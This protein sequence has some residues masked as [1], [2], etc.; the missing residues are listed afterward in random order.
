MTIIYTGPSLLDGAPIVVITISNSK[1]AKTGG[2]IQTYILRKD[3]DPRD[4]SKSGADYSI[5]GSC[6]ARGV[7]T[8]DPKVKL[9]VRRKCY[10]TIGQGPLIVWRKYCRGGY[11]AAPDAAAIAAIGADRMVRLGTYGDPAVV[12]AY[13]WSALLSKASGHTGYSHQAGMLGVNFD[14]S[15][16]MVSADSLADAQ[17]A[18]AIG[19]RTFRVIPRDKF[20]RD[21][22]ASLVAGKEIM[23][24]ASKESG[25]RT[26]CEHCL[27]C[28]G[29]SSNATKSIAIVA[30]GASANLINARL[31]A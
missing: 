17:N 29:T 2:M 31:V 4:A 27:L 10:V 8:N 15:I 23:C 28:A 22:M 13:V 3:V 18:W 24:P 11:A 20:A 16:M 5:C 1:N 9:A 30:H 7:A 21:G 14:S 12:P 26:T 6:G 25:Y 19:A